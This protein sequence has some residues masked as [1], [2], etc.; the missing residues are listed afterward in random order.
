MTVL[1]IYACASILLVFRLIFFL[2]VQYVRSISFFVR[3]WI[4]A[5]LLRQNEIDVEEVDFPVVPVEHPQVLDPLSDRVGNEKQNHESDQ[6]RHD[7]NGKFPLLERL[8]LVVFLLSHHI[9]HS[10]HGHTMRKQRLEKDIMQGTMPGARRRRRPRTAWMDN[11]K[12][13]TGLSVEE[14]SRMTEDRD[15]WRKYVHGVAN[16]RIEDG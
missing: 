1:L 7:L 14:S 5:S 6:W 16:P 12:T 9:H 11:I 4:S 13:C 8:C 15:K 2:L 3:A 10:Q